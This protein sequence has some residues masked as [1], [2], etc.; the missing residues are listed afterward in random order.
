MSEIN[1]AVHGQPAR[2]TV[3]REA[4]QVPA[5][6][7]HVY[8]V[9]LIGFEYLQSL[10][11]VSDLAEQDEPELGALFVEVPFV[12]QRRGRNP[13]TENDVGHSAIIVDELPSAISAR[14]NCIEV[15][16]RFV[17]VAVA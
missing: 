15:D 3:A 17:A 1:V 9:A 11:V 10:D 8:D 12:G 13:A 6:L 5:L 4:R 16:E 14:G 2:R 7:R